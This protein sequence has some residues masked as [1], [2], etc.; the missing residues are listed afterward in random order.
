MLLSLLTIADESKYSSL[1]V[2][3]GEERYSKLPNYRAG[4]ILAIQGD[5]PI[6]KFKYGLL[7]IEIKATHTILDISLDPDIAYH[8]I[9]VATIG[10]ST[11]YRYYFF[12]RLYT[13]LELG[14]TAQNYKWDYGDGHT[15][16]RDGTTFGLAGGVQLGVEVNREIT[17]Y[18]DYT[19]LD[20]GDLEQ[21]T[22]GVKWRF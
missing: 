10:V 6:K 1:G 20:R 21:I 15:H 14:A 7:G 4:K 3:L 22:F 5:K 12:K 18:G 2:S 16:D 11:T 9:Q 17:L 19:I 13:Q 8:K